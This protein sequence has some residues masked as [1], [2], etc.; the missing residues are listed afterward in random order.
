MKNHTEDRMI[1]VVLGL[2][3]A[4]PLFASQQLLEVYS[5]KAFLTQRFEVGSGLFKANLPQFVTLDALHVKSSCEVNKKSLGAPV[6]A[7]TPHLDELN[8]AKK[9]LDRAKMALQI[10]GAKE[11]LLERVNVDANMENIEAYTQKFETMLEGLLEKRGE[12]EEELKKAKEEYELLQTDPMVQKV[13]PLELSL[14]CDGPSL[15]ELRYPAE[16]LE[17][18]RKNRFEGDYETG[19]L[20]IEQNLFLGHLLGVD[21]QNVTLHLYGHAYSERL[22]PPA[23]HPWYLNGAILQPKRAMMAMSAPMNESMQMADSVDKNSQSKQFWEIS[24]LSLPSNETIQI[25]LDEQRLFAKYDLFIDGYSQGIAYVRG[26][27]VPQKPIDG[28]MGEFILGGALVGAGWHEPFE[29]KDESS[30]YFG[31]NELIGV[32]K[33]LREDFTTSNPAEKTQTTQVVYEYSLV[34]RGDMAYDI[35][36][37]E[38]LPVSRK[39]D[40]RVKVLGDKPMSS[41]AEGEVLYGLRLE[42]GESKTI[43]FGYVVTKPLPEK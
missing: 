40:V 3:L 21:L 13:K 1:R 16:S 6:Q 18:K 20:D 12:L 23:F 35:T 36:L 30:V 26:Q 4:L 2:L 9:V 11:R 17:V 25:K 34:N 7:S 29:T 19:I 38:R 28:A 31:K 43:R 33:T 22:A 32:E 39:G 37:S 15:L 10:Q 24:G 27:F 8:E 41:S 42:P 5:D 14:A